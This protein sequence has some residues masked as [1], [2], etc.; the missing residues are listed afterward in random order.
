[1]TS[2][3]LSATETRPLDE[4]A[5]II[6]FHAPVVAFTGAGISTESGIPDYRGRQGLWTTGASKPVMY[7]EFMNDP[8]ARRRWWHDVPERLD[9]FE[10]RSPNQGHDALVRLERAG[11]LGATIT[12]NI[13]GLHLKAG[14]SPERVVEL[15]GNAGTIRCTECGTIYPMREFLEEHADYDEPPPC[16]N[17]GGIVKSGSISFGQPVPE[18]ELRLAFG[19]ARQT[20][21]MLVVGST[22]LVNPAAQVPATSKAAGAYLAILNMGETPLDDRADM[23]VSVSAGPA[24]TYL[25]ERVL[26]DT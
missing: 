19:I 15:H 16:P 9:A 22:L 8:E 1:M 3:T 26:T 5:E 18:D 24:L 12:Q 21:V 20:G 2:D 7:D 6:R 23:T 10:E 17:C 4:L 14:A 13:D 25:V 11:I